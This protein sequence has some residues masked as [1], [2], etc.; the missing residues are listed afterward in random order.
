MTFLK[1]G[2]VFNSNFQNF[3]HTWGINVCVFNDDH[4]Q[5]IKMFLSYLSRPSTFSLSMKS[6][7]GNM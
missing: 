1:I 3:K 4:D 5:D 7:E 2:G 6:Y